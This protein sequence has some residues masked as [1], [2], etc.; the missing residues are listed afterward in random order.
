VPPSSCCMAGPMT[1][2]A[3]PITPALSSTIAVGG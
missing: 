1:F 2:T 3:I